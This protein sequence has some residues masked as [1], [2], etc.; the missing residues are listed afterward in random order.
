MSLPTD[1]ADVAVLALL[2]IGI[3]SLLLTVAFWTNAIVP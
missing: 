1:D 3:G 2:A